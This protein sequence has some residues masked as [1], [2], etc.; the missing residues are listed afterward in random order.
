MHFVY[1][2]ILRYITVLT[3]IVNVVWEFKCVGISTENITTQSTCSNSYCE[4]RIS[5]HIWVT[6]LTDRFSLNIADCNSRGLCNSS[7]SATY[8]TITWKSLAK[9]EIM[10][11]LGDR[12]LQNVQSGV[13]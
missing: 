1:L 3:W 10:K 7:F 11:F 4:N 5:C 12:A 2:K 9:F 6:S 13:T 8:T